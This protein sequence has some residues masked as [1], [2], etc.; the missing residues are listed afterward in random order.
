MVR[1]WVSFRVRI[2]ARDSLGLGLQ[3]GFTYS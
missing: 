3:S 1:I 2:R